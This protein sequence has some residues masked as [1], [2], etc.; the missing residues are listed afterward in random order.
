MSPSMLVGSSCSMAGPCSAYHSQRFAHLLISPR[1]WLTG[2]PISRASMR[3]MAS[4]LARMTVAILRRIS[5]RAS[6]G[7][8][9][10][11]RKALSVDCSTVSRSSADWNG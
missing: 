5:T 2:M 1:A 7:V 10:H 9:R 3:A 4:T 6:T 11:W 8:S